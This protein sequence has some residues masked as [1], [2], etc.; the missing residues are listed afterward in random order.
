MTT[1]IIGTGSALPAYVMSNDDLACLVDTSDEWI[2]SRTGIERRRLA[3]EKEDCVSL[4]A[5]AGRKALEDGG[6]RPEEIDLLIV[7]TCSSESYF[8]SVACQVQGI[9]GIPSCAAFDLNAAC[10]GFLFAL[11]TADAYIR[12]GIYRKALLIGAE[13]L[14]RVIS[15]EDRATCV[16]FGDG[17]GAC[18][19]QA[20]QEGLEDFIQSADGALGHVLTARGATGR[21]PCLEARA[22]QPVSMDGKEVFKFAVT[23]VPECIRQILERNQADPQE[24]RYYVLHQANRRI[25]Q[26]VARRLQ[27]P[28]ERFPLNLQ[29]YGNTSAASIPILLDE[30]NRR[31]QLRR[32]DRLILSG[33]GAGL[34]WGAALLRW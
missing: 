23:R 17:A 5:E 15:W 24:I 13:T 26:S 12:A 33:F 28:E 9:L 27:I 32:G 10:S 7:A 2:R 20:D 14:S 3:G 30:M 8:P 18:A 34:T 19:V 4:A 16:L 21:T 6:I 31:G 22:M 1:R 29:E 11:N 25:I